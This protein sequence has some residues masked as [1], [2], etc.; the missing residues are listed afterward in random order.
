MVDGRVYDTLRA[1]D[2]AIVASGT[3]TLETGLMAVPMA[4][5]YRVSALNYFILTKLAPGVK[6]VG[7]VNIVAGRR[8]VPELVQKDSTPGNMADTIAAFL[9]D[10]VHAQRVRNDLI[11]IRA[12]LGD[13]GASLRAAQ[14]VG[15][16]LAGTG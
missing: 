10:P 3:A 8:I 12:R 5:V 11:D 14:V 16:L 13:A 1:A 2:A 4:I 15:E 6:D 9:D 7:L